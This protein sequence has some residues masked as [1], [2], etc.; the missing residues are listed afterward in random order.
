MEC[1]NGT[2]ILSDFISRPVDAARALPDLTAEQLNAH[3]GG[4]PNS[5]AWLL[6]HTGREIDVQTADLTGGPQAWDTGDFR[7]RFNLGPVGDAVGFGQSPQE[8]AG[9]RV[10]DQQLLLAYLEASMNSLQTYVSGLSDD[11]LGE[12]IDDNWTPPVTRGVRV[13]SIIDDAAQHM[14]QAAYTAGILTR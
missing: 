2:D 12:V 5:V 3:P 1:M 4:H 13:I 9:I 8:A 14:G 7:D 10:D 11:D 6:W